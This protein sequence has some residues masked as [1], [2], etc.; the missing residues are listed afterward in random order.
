VLGSLAEMAN[1]LGDPV[2][3]ARLFGASRGIRDAIGTSHAPDQ[4]E[5]YERVLGL[6][7]AGAG[8]EAFAAAWTA[9]MTAPLDEIVQDACRMT[10]LANA[11]PQDPRE[12]QLEQSTGLTSRE[13][14]VIR[15]MVKGRSN[16]EIADALSLNVGFVATVIG[17]IYTKLAVDTHA[18]V[19]AFAFKN[20]IV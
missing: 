17:Q 11:T 14:S 10:Q 12:V 13:I 19:T 7:R 8:E 15:E 6:V 3:G 2:L 1:T 9:G 16:Q 18:G 20:G 5:D 4:I